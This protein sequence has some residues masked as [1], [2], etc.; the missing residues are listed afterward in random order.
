MLPPLLGYLIV[1]GYGKHVRLMVSVKNKNRDI[2]FFLVDGFS[3]RINN[4][5]LG[6]VFTVHIINFDAIDNF[7]RFQVSG[8]APNQSQG[9]HAG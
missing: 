5:C 6:I 9:S 7:N 2:S 4:I 3:F 8:R 1:G